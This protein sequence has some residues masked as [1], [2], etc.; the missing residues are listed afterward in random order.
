MKKTKQDYA[1]EIV[2]LQAAMHGAV[3]C[4]KTTTGFAIVRVIRDGSYMRQTTLLR[5]NDIAKAAARMRKEYKTC[6][7]AQGDLFAT[8]KNPARRHE[9]DAARL[10]ERF[11]G[12]A[13]D[14]DEYQ[15]IA[16]PKFPDAMACIGQIFAIEYLA[17]RDGKEYRFRHVFKAKSRPQLAVSPDGKI[18]SMLGGAWFFGEDGFEDF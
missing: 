4:R 16:K 13:P 3:V 8:R 10:A 11:H 18:A 2:D 7:I 15:T 6:G 14:V 9:S 5:T 1:E 12:R 17:E